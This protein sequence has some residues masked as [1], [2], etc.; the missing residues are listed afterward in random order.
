MPENGFP[1]LLFGVNLDPPQRALPVKGILRAGIDDLLGLDPP[2][3]PARRLQGQ[4][5]LPGQQLSSRIMRL[6][7]TTP[8][9]ILETRRSARTGSA[10][11]DRRWPYLK[12]H[13]WIAER[14][15]TGNSLPEPPASH[16]RTQIPGVAC[17]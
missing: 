1:H 4:R 2:A 8:R 15:S 14:A 5:Y 12:N 6:V 17:F 13:D 10:A 7:S 3:D 11:C 9:E 16:D